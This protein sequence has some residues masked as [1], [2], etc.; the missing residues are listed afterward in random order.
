M[1]KSI[2]IK[3]ME[4]GPDFPHTGVLI[5]NPEKRASREGDK[6]KFENKILPRQR[7]SAFKRTKNV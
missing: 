4:H 5:Y 2:N 6:N 3:Y 7:K 1:E